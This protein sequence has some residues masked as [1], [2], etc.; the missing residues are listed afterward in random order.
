MSNS[1]KIIDVSNLL[2]KYAGKTIYLVIADKNDEPWF[3]AKDC[4]DFFGYINTKR[5]IRN[6]VS[7]ENR[8]QLNEIVFEYKDLYKNIQGHSVYINEEGFYE[9]LFRSNK[10]DAKEIQKWLAS[11]VLPTLR[12]EGHYEIEKRV[13]LKLK[14]VNEKYEEIKKQN[15]KIKNRNK[16]L[17]HNQKKQKYPKGGGIYIM[18]PNINSPKDVNKIGLFHKNPNER[19]SNY[20]TTVPDDIDDVIVVYVED[21]DGTETCLKGML[22][23]YIYRG[24]KEFYRCSV[25]EILRCLDACVFTTEGRHI[26]LY[27]KDMSRLD[28]MEETDEEYLF[29]FIED[30]ID[31]EDSDEDDELQ[32]GGRINYEL[33][34]YKYYAKNLKLL[35]KMR[36]SNII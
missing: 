33:K 15:K 36:K 1:G 22:H 9:L 26:D 18:R 4:A 31:S 30:D 20:N 3:N 34:Y 32:E 29:E 13:R 6:Y 21:P 8:K 19:F 14:E 2:I 7:V 35:L 12:K 24:K 5:T 17:E 27:K 11:D 28:T 16:E 23:K 10:S 25:K